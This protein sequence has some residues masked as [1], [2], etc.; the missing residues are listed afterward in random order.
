M[1]KNLIFDFGGVLL[2]LNP[3]RCKSAFRSLGFYEI[4]TL[5]SLSHQQSIFD[6]IERGELSVPKFCEVLR[7]RISSACLMRYLFRPLPT[8]QEL[9][10]AW[11]AMADGI[12]HYRLQAVSDLRSL[13]YRVSALSNTNIPHWEHCRPLF[14]AAGYC[15]EELFEYLWLSCELHMV[16]PDPRLFSHLLDESGYCPEETLFIDDAP[17]NCRAAESFGIRTYTPEVRKDWRPELYDLLR[18]EGAESAPVIS[19]PCTY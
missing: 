15:S 14:E 6:Q 7:Q 19:S 11:C 8:D 1:I 13:G 12:P 4:D 9:L 5:L 16:K 2:D 10:D 3:E 18:C 17:A